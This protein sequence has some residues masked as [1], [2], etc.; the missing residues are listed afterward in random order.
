[1]PDISMLYSTFPTA[2][3]AFSVARKLLEMRLIAC[4]NVISGATSLYRWEGEIQQ[5]NEAVLIAKTASAMLPA[6]MEALKNLH[7][8]E[9]PC[10]LTYPAS[11]GFPHFMQ[12]VESEASGR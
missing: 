6:A 2:D 4:A 12:W 10:I 1:M 5:E 3:E 7:P 8:Y 11:G 9:V